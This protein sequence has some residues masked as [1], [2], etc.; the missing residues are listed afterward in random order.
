MEMRAAVGGEEPKM[1]MRSAMPA[2]WNDNDV[3]EALI[4]AI[5]EAEPT[6]YAWPVAVYADYVVYQMEERGPAPDYKYTTKMYRRDFTFDKEAKAYTLGDARKEVE[7]VMTYEVLQAG[8]EAVQ[9]ETKPPCGCGGHKPV[10]AASAAGE[11]NMERKDRIAALVA[12]PHN[13]VKELKMLEAA[14]EESLKALEDA[15]TAAKKTADDLRVAQEATTKAEQKA[16]E[17]ATAL[18]TLDTSFKTL[19]ASAQP[20]IDAAKA[21]EQAEKDTLVGKLKACTAGILTEEQL[22]AKP[23]EELRNLAKIAK[24]DEAPVQAPNFA[25]AGMPRFAAAGGLDVTK[26]NAPDPYASLTAAAK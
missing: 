2:G 6:T 19:Q 25:G 7:P 9:V 8:S 15:A 4:K 18:A 22:K 12:N 5:R 11:P 13:P 24:V 26:F 16:V 14:S 10:I 1:A 20:L 23:V 21:A 17:T 3:R